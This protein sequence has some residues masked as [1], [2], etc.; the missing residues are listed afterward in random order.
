MSA[1][2]HI[3]SVKKNLDQAFPDLTTQEL[4]AILQFAK[5]VRFRARNNV[6]LDNLCR[7]LF[8][9]FNVKHI[10]IRVDGRER[11]QMMVGGTV[12]EESTDD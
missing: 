2:G 8:P 7:Q 3:L 5:L 1:Q 6:A 10:K 4:V 9:E 11:T 12:L